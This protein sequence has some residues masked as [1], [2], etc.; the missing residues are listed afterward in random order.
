MYSYKELSQ[1]FEEIKKSF[2]LRGV[3][4]KELDE[5]RLLAEELN[6]LSNKLV[7]LN[8]KKNSLVKDNLDR[9]EIRNLK[10]EIGT[11]SV[12][13][14]ELSERVHMAL[15]KLPNIPDDSLTDKEELIKE[16]GVIKQYS[17]KP[18]SHKELAIKNNLFD[19]SLGA[20]IAGSGYVVYTDFGAKLFRALMQFTIDHNESKGY[21][22]KYIPVVVNQNTLFGTAQLPKFEKDLFKVSDSKYLSPTAET[23]LVNLYKNKIITASDLPIKVTANSNCFR[24]EAG[25]AGVES[26]GIIRLH[27]FNKTEIVVFCEPKDSFEWL[28]TMVRDASG[29]LERLNLPY[30]VIQL[31]YNDMSFASTKTYDIEVWFPSENRYREISSVSNTLAFQAK[32]AKIRYKEDI[33]SKSEKTKFPHIL[34]GSSLAID[35]LFAALIENYQCEDGTISIPEELSRYIMCQK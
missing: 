15:A 14:K 19:L 9:N 7:E 13:E 35:R 32:R 33:F 11:L 27:Q 2:K 21:K 16:W 22:Q 26:S 12:Q 29:I 5:A 6:N 25:A 34:N 24:L 17:F 31:P 10:N 1:N 23:Q 20:D 3:E 8:T 30:R 28:E 4:E 18:L